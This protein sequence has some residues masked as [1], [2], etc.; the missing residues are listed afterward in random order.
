M[1]LAWQALCLGKGIYFKIALRR[2]LKNP[3]RTVNMIMMHVIIRHNA[4]WYLFFLLMLYIQCGAVITWS[5][6]SKI[7]TIDIPWAKYRV[8]V[9]LNSDLIS[10]TVHSVEIP[11]TVDP[12]WNILYWGSK[13]NFH[14]V[15]WG[16]V[17]CEWGTTSVYFGITCV[18]VTLSRRPAFTVEPQYQHQDFLFLSKLSFEGHTQNLRKKSC[19]F[20]IWMGFVGQIL[21][22]LI[23][24]SIWGFL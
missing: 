1:I 15:C 20:K 22:K 4:F 10:S 7:L 19:W 16:A 5:M 13:W 3:L 18:C 12:Q 11:S 23:T 14:R 8:S 6:F 2:L 9:I 21:I 17:G 24:S